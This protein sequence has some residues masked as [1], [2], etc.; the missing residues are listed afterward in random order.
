MLQ[1]MNQGIYENHIS[2]HACAYLHNYSRRM[3]EPLLDTRYD[4]VTKAAPLY[5]IDDY[6]KLEE[7]IRKMVGCGKGM[8]ILYEIAKG[9]IRPSRKLVDC[10]DSLYKGNDD[11]VLL[12]EQNIAYQTIVRQLKDL[13]IKRTIIVKG[14]PGTGKSVISFKVLHQLIDRRLNAKFVAPNEAFREV[15]IEKLVSSKADKK[16][17]IKPLFG[18]SG[19]FYDC[20]E[21]LY[22]VLV[23]D[24]AHRLKGKGAYMYRGTNQVRD[25]IRAS[26]LNVFFVDDTQRVRP[27]DIGTVNEIRKQAEAEGSE[28]YEMEL[29]AQYRCAG[30][31][32]F[33][34]WVTHTL[35][36]EDTANYNGWEKE[37]FEFGL[38]ENP[39]DLYHKILE[40]NTEGREARLVAGFAWDWSKD[41]DAGVNDVSIPEWNFSL[42]WNARNQR[43][44]Y[45]IKEDSVNQ[46]GC[47]HTVQGL[48]FDY[49]GVIIGDDLRYDPMTHELYGDYDNYRDKSGKKGLKG[50]QKRLT[51]YIKNI[52]KV[53]MSRG[54]RGCY[55]YCRDSQVQKYFEERLRLIHYAD[56]IHKLQSKEK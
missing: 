4:D 53:L 29:K 13:R 28:V 52:Y 43:A 31:E 41:P 1:N 9:R 36:I 45:A 7:F 2:G 3:P 54:T 10:V 16:K 55:I 46:V 49:V 6:R 50:Q 33:V 20:P 21:N 47:I 44:Y 19:T 11:F 25:I 39:N 51:A 48:E 18:G 34:N 37:K 40:M 38:Y 27:D 23:V 42:P 12:D 22:D 32:G 5:F 24:E 17:N 35:Q 8:P 56:A 30:A 14:G 26:V 15:M